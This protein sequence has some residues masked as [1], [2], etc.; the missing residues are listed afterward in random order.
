MQKKARLVP[1][2]APKQRASLTI[3]PVWQKKPE[4]KVRISP[5]LVE[6]LILGSRW[7]TIN[8]F[9]IEFRISASSL[10]KYIRGETSEIRTKTLVKLAVAFPSKVKTFE[11][12]AVT[13][14]L[15][16]DLIEEEKAELAKPKPEPMP[17]L[18]KKKPAPVKKKSAVA[19]PSQKR[20]KKK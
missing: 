14:R 10:Y 1:S 8:N 4:P 11:Y 6:R 17:K 20:K 5:E 2:P 3:R 18:S 19:K 7:E 12:D 16:K 13:I 15:F 9:A